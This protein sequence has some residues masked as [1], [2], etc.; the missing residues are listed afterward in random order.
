MMRLLILLLCFFSIAHAQDNN[1]TIPIDKG[2]PVIVRT[3]LYYNDLKAFNDNQETFEA[4]TDLRL[5]WED[6]RLSYQE[7]ENVYDYKEFRASHAEEEIAKIWTP[8]IQFANQVGE[9]TFSERRLRFYP[10]GKVE[11]M[12][13]TTAIYKTPID[14]S[15]FPF[16]HQRLEIHIAVREDTLENVV[17]DFL[18]EDMEFSRASKN[19]TLKDWTLSWVNLKRQ[20]IH[21]WNGDHYAQVIA[22]LKL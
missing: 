7:S 9:P 1:L 13:R 18:S 3:A 5:I 16:D 10:T 19:A 8:K 22:S 12:I 15:H 2:L 4:T 11:L 20:V 14:G 21:G 6:P 17:L